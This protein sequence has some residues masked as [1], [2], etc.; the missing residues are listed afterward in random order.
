MASVMAA[1]HPALDCHLSVGGEVP[2]MA[3]GA[4]LRSRKRIRG[5][6]RHAD[7]PLCLCGC[8]EQVRLRTRRY[9][10]GHVPHAIRAEGGRK[11]GMSRVYRRKAA[12]FEQVFADLTREGQ[13]ITKETLLTILADTYRRAYS[14]GY[15]ACEAK[16]KTTGP[17]RAKV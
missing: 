14:T 13:R 9:V 12:E 11:G 16:W 8:G 7:A 2:P 5:P 15:K 1:G 4:P 6:R 3:P 10:Y 17:R